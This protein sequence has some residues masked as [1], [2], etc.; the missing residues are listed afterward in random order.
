MDWLADRVDSLA[1]QAAE[2]SVYDVKAAVRK[3]QAYA[4]NYTEA[5]SRVREATNDEPWGASS[6]LMQQIAQDTFNFQTF[7]EIMPTLYSRFTEKEAREWRQ[8][9]K[10]LQLLEYLVKNGSERVV[11]DARSHLSLV[12]VL[13]NFHYVDENGKDQGINI[14]NRAKELGDLLSDVERV[15]QE[16]RKAKQNRNKYQGVGSDGYSGGGGGS[17][18]F[19]GGGGPSFNSASGSRYGGF[20]SDSLGSGGGGDAYS[21]GGGSGGFS[22]SRGRQ[23]DFEAYDAGDDEDLD[24]RRAAP[25]RAPSAS[26]SSARTG[27]ARAGANK[28]T[29]PAPAPAPA[30][31]KT[32]QPE[33]NLFDFDDDEPLAASTP[34][35]PPKPVTFSAP[36]A[37]AVADDD[38]DDFQSAAPAPFA[39]APAPAAPRAGA[40]T[41]VFDLLQPASSS[42]GGVRPAST[43]AVAAA[44]PPAYHQAQQARPALQ[45]ALSAGAPAPQQQAKAKPAGDFSDLFELVSPSP[46]AGAK[47]GQGG[48]K[49]SLA[50]IAAQK[51]QDSLFGAGGAAGGA[52][53][54]GAGDGW[55]SLL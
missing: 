43:P 16:R 41:N 35:P 40:G 15:R 47:P 23:D 11:D 18:G 27:A 10:A 24:V 9:Y 25:G 28:P 52:K 14:R 26:S 19:S 48:A 32:K 38:F 1:K 55:D 17:G 6:S 53:G 20:G 3:A 42:S 44:A 54:M 45:P 8:I 50:E 2:L 12:R 39:A 4:F 34:A 51:R 29:P 22:D 46:S 30:P 33:V 21:G 37:A 31:P 7:N 36:P 5:E 13:R 49:Q